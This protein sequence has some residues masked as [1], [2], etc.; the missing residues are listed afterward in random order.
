MVRYTLSAGDQMMSSAWPQT[1]TR[2]FLVKELETQREHSKDTHK[3]HMRKRRR[4][5]SPPGELKS[6]GEISRMKRKCHRENI[7]EKRGRISKDTR[8]CELY[9]I[10]L[11][12]RILGVGNDER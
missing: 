6:C 9:S 12:F 2:S 1:P 5:E 11:T 10:L 4:L 3:R 7:P 8:Y